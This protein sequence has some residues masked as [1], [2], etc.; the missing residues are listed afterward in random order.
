[1]LVEDVGERPDE[2]K[3]LLVP[4][5]ERLTERQVARQDPVPQDLHDLPQL[6]RQAKHLGVRVAGR[7]CWRSWRRR[8]GFGELAPGEV[9][10]GLAR[11][12]LVERRRRRSSKRGHRL[13]CS[14]GRSW[15]VGR[16]RKGNVNR[17]R[18]PERV[19]SVERVVQERL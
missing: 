14:A 3:L 1:M 11:L 15:S 19:R 13:V 18:L 6:V 9:G 4:S 17:F 12:G 10:R 16:V 2:R 7:P 8:G 5:L